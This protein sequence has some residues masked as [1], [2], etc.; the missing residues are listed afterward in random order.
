MELCFLTKEK[1]V[2]RLIMDRLES[3]DCHCYMQ[4]DWIYLY[5]SL[6]SY[7]CSIDMIICDFQVMGCAYF[8]LFEVIAE[9]GKKI[10]V[11]YYNDPLPSDEERIE[12]WI[13]QN[14]LCYSSKF[15]SVYLDIL[16]SLNKIV[17]DPSI[18]RH[19]ALMQPAVPVGFKTLKQGTHCREIDLNQFRIRNSLSPSLFRLFVF[20]YKNRSKELSI[21]RIERAVFGGKFD[22]F[23]RKSS[24]YSYISRL[25]KSIEN[26]SFVKIDI[27]RCDKGS[28]QMILY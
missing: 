27:I 13:S 3:K 28:Y 7:K 16:N 21:K 4:D 26:D 22:F 1:N 24:V 5:K 23:D 8:N 20:M 17:S 25:R 15:E 12:H 19:I 6:Q 18:K 9:M 14:E 11:I 2:C 10:P